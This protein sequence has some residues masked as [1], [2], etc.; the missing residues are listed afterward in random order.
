MS[1]II[2]GLVK[3]LEEITGFGE[4]FEMAESQS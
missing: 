3:D 2:P 1:R 4:E